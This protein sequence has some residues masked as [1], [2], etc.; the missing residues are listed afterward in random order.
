[1]NSLKSKAGII[2]V[3]FLLPAL[4]LMVSGTLYLAFGIEG[5]NKFLGVC[6]SNPA[7]RLLFSPVLV[8]GGPGLVVMLNIWTVCH[9][10]AESIHD[11]IVIALSIKR[12]FSNLACAGVAGVLIVLLLSY[13]FVENFQIV[14]R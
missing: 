8:L 10:S 6:L 11:E 9:L 7:G 2:S 4:I 1:M 12:V 3:A 5:A 13:A 14:A